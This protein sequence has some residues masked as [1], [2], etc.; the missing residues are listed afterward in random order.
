MTTVPVRKTSGF[1][2]TLVIYECGCIGGFVVCTLELVKNHPKFS[3]KHFSSK[4][5]HN[6]NC[7]NRL[8]QATS[9]IKKNCLKLTIISNGENSPNMVTLLLREGVISSFSSS[10][11]R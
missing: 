3:P 9:V 4:F 1:K 8:P 7:G 2:P 5:R 11:F 10:N 6:F